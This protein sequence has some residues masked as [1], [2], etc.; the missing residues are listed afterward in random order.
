[1]SSYH[2]LVYLIEV[3]SLG[4]CDTDKISMVRMQYSLV[5]LAAMVSARCGVGIV[6]LSDE[7]IVVMG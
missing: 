3:P 1:M 7:S 6:T 4:E 5:P 2:H